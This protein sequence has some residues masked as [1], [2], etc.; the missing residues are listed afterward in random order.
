[1]NGCGLLA[2]GQSVQLELSQAL[3]GTPTLLV[4]GASEIS[5]PL[6]GGTL[7][8]S[9]DLILSGFVTN[10]AGEL[11]ITLPIGVPIPAGLDRFVQAWSFDSLGN[12][13]GSNAVRVSTL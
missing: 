9:P 3:A 1:M 12:V 11:E 10:G 6:L 7:V 2:L 13:G 4:V 5:F 8:P